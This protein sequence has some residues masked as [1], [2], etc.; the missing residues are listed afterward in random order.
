[1]SAIANDYEDF[2]M[3]VSEVTEWARRA[4]LSF[5]PAEIFAS[6]EELIE[7]GLAIACRLSPNSP[8]EGISPGS[9]E[10]MPDDCY[11]FLT[12]EGKASLD[13]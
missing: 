8:P 2:E 6:L 7:K 11:F 9:L 5:T 1:M 12:A 10:V 3:I 13:D 4:G